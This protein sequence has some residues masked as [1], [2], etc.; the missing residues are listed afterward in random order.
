MRTV[1]TTVRLAREAL[2]L[3]RDAGLASQDILILA[4]VTRSSGLGRLHTEPAAAYSE[5]MKT[6][7]LTVAVAALGF[8]GSATAQMVPIEWDA[9]GQFSKEVAIAP[10]KFVEACEKLP[11]GA[12]V[13]WSFEAPSH[14]DFN[15]HFHEG[16]QVRF[17]AKKNQ[18]AK[19]AGTL[20]TKVEQD[21][22]W[23]WTNKGAAETTLNLKLTKG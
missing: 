9:S 16:K 8:C 3:Y 2:P 22:C 21:Y 13:A 18:V 20:N 1:F 14:L 23:M 12:K 6:L 11:K 7:M 10:G 4:T 5:G 15:I 17:P 19:D